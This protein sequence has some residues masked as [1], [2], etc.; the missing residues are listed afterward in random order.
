MI[1]VWFKII[2]PR[3][4]Y[5]KHACET[6]RMNQST[7]PIVL[8]IET[9][10]R[11]GSV[12]V[13]RGMSVLASRTGDATTSH[14][15]DLLENIDRVLRDARTKLDEIDFF[16]AAVGPGSFTG[17]RIG[18]ATTKS[19]AVALHRNCAGV[20]TLAAIAYQAGPSARTIALLPAG[21]GELFAQLFAVTE[22]RADALDD[23][24]HVSPENMIATYGNHERVIWVGEGAH[25]QLELLKTE[26]AARDIQFS[27]DTVIFANGASR[28]WVLAPTFY[29]VSDAVARL[30]FQQWR[31]GA[32]ID[33][34]DL[35]ANYVRPSDAEI[36]STH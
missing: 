31:S 18:L 32:L 10:T 11:A 22:E 27:L 24:A 3:I 30:A 2:A 33:P 34:G 21:R 14:S 12:S 35:K 15:S 16:A 19:L 17:V 9:A 6:V 20:S 28:E 8:A 7:E 5:V 29:N 1:V 4:A 13:A 36:K 25:A 23:A 26:A